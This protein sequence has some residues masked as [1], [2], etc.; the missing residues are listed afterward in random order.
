M[1][2]YEVEVTQRK[3]DKARVVHKNFSSFELARSYADEMTMDNRTVKCS[4]Y[5]NNCLVMDVL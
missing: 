2:N 5:K 3:E 1:K 4:I